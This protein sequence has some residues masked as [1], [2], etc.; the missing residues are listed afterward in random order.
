MPLRLDA[1]SAVVSAPSSP[2]RP[3]E[4]FRCSQG[5]VSRYGPGDGLPRL[6]VLAGRDHGVGPAVSNG[7]V[8]FARIVS[9]VCGDAADRLVPPGSG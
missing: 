2:E 9:A 1:A 6:G 8:A 7:I 3:A 4:V 5:F